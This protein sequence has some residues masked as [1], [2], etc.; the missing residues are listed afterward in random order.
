MLILSFDS[1]R[2]GFKLILAAFAELLKYFVEKL[3]V[4]GGC[5]RYWHQLGRPQLIIENGRN[6]LMCVLV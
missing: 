3:A 6:M 1:H 2:S 5:G 4:G